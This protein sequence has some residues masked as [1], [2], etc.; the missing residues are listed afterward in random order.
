MDKTKQFEDLKKISKNYS[1]QLKNAINISSM[2]IHDVSVFTSGRAVEDTINNY[3]RLLMENQKTRRIR[4]KDYR[5]DAKIGLLKK[6]SLIDDKLYHDLS[7]VRISRNDTG[8]PKRASFKQ[9]DA[10]EAVRQA[11]SIIIKLEKQ[12]KILNK[13][14]KPRFTK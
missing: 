13:S 8:H 14:T 4:L 12:I 11:I 3:F 5:F 9:N 1:T 7:S 2:G 6:Q 10:F